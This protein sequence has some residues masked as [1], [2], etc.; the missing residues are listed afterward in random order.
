MMILCDLIIPN[1]NVANH[2]KT[3]EAMMF[4][5]PVITNV[6]PALVNEVGCAIFLDY[7]DLKEIKSSIVRLWDDNKLRK[8]LGDNSHHAFEQKY[9][10]CIMK[11]QLYK[12]YKRLLID[13]MFILEV[14]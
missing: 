3:F 6:T 12:V 2:N 13:R 10:W 8:R 11:K 1:H 14:M 5:L 7:N 4:V 9:N